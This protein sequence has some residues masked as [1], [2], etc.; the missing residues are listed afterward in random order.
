M[1]ETYEEMKTR[2]KPEIYELERRDTGR[3]AKMSRGLNGSEG[4]DSWEEPEIEATVR[5]RSTRRYI[6]RAHLNSL[7]L[8][9]PEGP[10]GRFPRGFNAT[11]EEVILALVG[12]EPI[13]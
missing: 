2:I 7:T 5:I 9:I 3:V 4:Y 1:S 13:F 10:S 12:D 11:D 6:A 8:A